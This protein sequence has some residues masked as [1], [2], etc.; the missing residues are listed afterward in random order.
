MLYADGTMGYVM[1]Q[2]IRI[3]NSKGIPIKTYGVNQDISE[4]KLAQKKL[5]ESEEK[6][7]RS[8]KMESLGLLAGSVAHDLNNVLS[9]IVSYPELL[10]LDLPESS[11]LRKPIETIQ[12][13]GNRAVAIVQDLLTIARGAAIIKEPINLND[14]ITEYMTSPEF[15]NLKKNHPCVDYKIALNYDLFRINGSPIHIKKVIMNL[16][17][18]A[19]EAI[20]NHGNVTVST[21]NRYVDKPLSKYEDVKVGEYIVLTVLDDGPGIAPENLD[22][23]FEPFFTKKVM[24]VSGTGL[25]LTVVWNTVQDHSGYIDVTSDKNG[26]KF[27][28]YF[29]ITR[30]ESINETSSVSLDELKG[31][32][33]LIL[34]VDDVKNQREISCQMLDSLGYKYMAVPSGEKAIEYLKDNKVDLV[35]LD[36][37][38]T[39]GISG[40]KTYEQIVKIHPGQKAVI[41]SGYTET[42]DVVATQK[43][44]AGRYIRKPFTLESLGQGIKEELNKG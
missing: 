39:P 33:E 9:G 21:N 30:E 31:N 26:T 8:K 18:N 23:I 37:I 25:G 17:S 3:R 34:V 36:M 43:M 27:E 19:S 6:L 32:G 10:L 13:S 1:A 41:I 28:L 15:S 4:W 40:R 7:A 11:K 24:G 44:G 42:E 35:L 16:V 12:E 38:M 20:E 29:P 5:R 22:R 14:I 2:T